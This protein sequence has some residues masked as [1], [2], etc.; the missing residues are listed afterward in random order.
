MTDRIEKQ[1]EINAS[2]SRVWK[3][4][5]DAEEFGQ[6][7]KVK[8]EG[9]FVVGQT[10]R[11]Q[12]THPGYEHVVWQAG[13][14]AIEPEHY[15]A[16]TWHPYAV[17]PDVDYSDEPPTLI[18]FTLE[19]IAAGTLLR[20]VESGFDKI[21]PGRRPEAVRMNTHGWEVQMKNIKQHVE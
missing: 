11:G 1:I 8:L 7:F 16:F 4:L 21:P 13:V 17:D 12:I 18:E 2:Q 10:T 9:P 5:V 15:F 19:P 20:V 6:W 14:K 3:A